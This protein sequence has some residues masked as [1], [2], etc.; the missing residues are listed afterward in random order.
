MPANDEKSSGER[1]VCALCQTR[2]QACTYDAEAGVTRVEALRRRNAELVSQNADFDIVLSA[3]RTSSDADAVNHLHQLRAAPDA[4]T[5]AQVLKK[6]AGTSR[7]RKP[8]DGAS[9]MEGVPIPPHVTRSETEITDRSG[10]LVE[11]TPDS[12]DAATI[13]VQT[14][15][16][17]LPMLPPTSKRAYTQPMARNLAEVWPYTETA[18]S[19]MSMMMNDRSA[20]TLQPQP[21]PALEGWGVTP[22]AY[23]RMF[24]VPL[25]ESQAA[26]AAAT[27]LR[28]EDLSMDDLQLQQWSNWQSW[29]HPNA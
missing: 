25:T 3:L 1:P 14:V 24:D 18:D 11:E 16:Q 21:P 17:S 15:E 22:E 19:T 6:Q 10:S 12:L 4:E 13:H 20:S 2:G 27:R 5:Y 9:N 23:H 7:R 28:Q 8:A 26:M 29:N